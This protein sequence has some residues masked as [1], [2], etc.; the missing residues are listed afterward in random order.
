MSSVSKN[1]QAVLISFAPIFDGLLIAI[2]GWVAYGLRWSDWSM[3]QNYL[4]VLMLGTALAVVLLPLSG[5][6][7]SWRGRVQW[8][9]IGNALPGLIS[10]A[11][12]LSFFGT[13]TKST[14]EYS[15]LWMGY[16]LILAVILMFSLR[17]LN[18]A[19]ARLERVSATRRRQVLIVGDGQIASSIAHKIQ[20][21]AD[22]SL[23]VWG[24]I[25]AGHP[26]LAVNLPGPVVGNL[27]EL[28]SI[29][30]APDC[31]IEE[32]WIVAGDLDLDQRQLIL[33]VLL[34]TYL[35]IRYVPDLSV[36][37]LL[38]HVPSEVAGI[39]VIDLNGSPL[40]D[41]NALLKAGFDKLFASATLLI[42]APILCLVAL[43]I[44]L[45]SP[46]PIFFQQRRHGW[47]GSIFQVLKFRTMTQPESSEDLERQAVKND[48]R[49]TS[50]GRFL[51]RSSLDELPQFLNVL[52]GNMSVVGPRPHPVTL[53]DSFV[54]QIDAYMRRHRVKP[55]ITGWAQV[56]G[57][58]GETDTLEKMQ[59]R[60]EYDLYYIEHWSLWL[61]IKI[62][63]QT[64]VTGWAGKNAY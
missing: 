13:M 58:R 26:A 59:K 51:R 55:G 54:N 48:P 2:A 43:A 49:V 22:S 1:G 20:T 18:T 6:Y 36:L 15:R 39:T 11:V 47:D 34:N 41:H 31:K 60:I 33:K 61:D 52:M 3:P 25:A 28:G 37:A 9:S 53:N 63:L 8:S 62:I 57:L 14:A 46:G 17:W 10:V 24:F 16:W 12:I 21:N 56:H 32:V 4:F 27:E 38:N 30:S 7:Q 35:T 29:L 42:L 5:A 19:F 23:V 50:V 64:L 40:D 45:D 44:K